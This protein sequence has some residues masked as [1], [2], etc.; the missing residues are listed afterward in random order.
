[1]KLGGW[2]IKMNNILNN[3]TTN[4][5][6]VIPP[7]CCKKRMKVIEYNDVYARDEKI[8]FQCEKCGIVKIITIKDISEVF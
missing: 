8:I 4:E 5:I 1:M 3:T 2:G 7:K 6:T